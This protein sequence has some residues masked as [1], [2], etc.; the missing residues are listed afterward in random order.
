MSNEVVTLTFTSAIG[1]TAWLLHPLDISRRG[2][3]RPYD[4]LRSLNNPIAPPTPQKKK[5]NW[6]KEGF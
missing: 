5:V 2:V 1:K 4:A 3:S 6:A